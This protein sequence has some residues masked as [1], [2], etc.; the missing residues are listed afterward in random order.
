M[1]Q[2]IELRSSGLT[3]T[4][5]SE[6]PWLYFFLAIAPYLLVFLRAEASLQMILTDVA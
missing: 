5:L 3:L 6:Q 4:D 2:G 1:G